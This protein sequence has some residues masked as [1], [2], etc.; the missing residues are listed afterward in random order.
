[1]TVTVNPTPVLTSTLT[2]TPVCDNGSVSYTPTTL[3]SG[4]SFAWSRAAVSGIA[5]SA[6][7]GTNGFAESLDN[8]GTATATVSYVYTLTANGCSNVETV[9]V[10]VYPTPVLTSTLTPASICNLTTFSYAPTSATSGTTFSWSRAAVAG[11][12]NSASSGIN[13]PNETLENTTADPIAVDYVYTL[14]ANG[15]TNVETVTVTVNPG[16][17]MSS[18]LTPAAICDSTLFSYVPTSATSGTVFNWSRASVSGIS[19]TAA[20]GTGNPSEYLNNTSTAPVTVTYVYTL[21][22]SGCSGIQ[23]VSVVVNP[24]PELTSTLTPAAQCNSTLFTYVP[25]SATTG[26]AFE[27][28]RASVSGISNSAATGTDGISE[29]LVNTSTDPVTV[30]YVYTLTANN[31]TNIQNV[32]VVINPTPVLTSTLTANPICDNTTFN[33]IPTS[34]TLGSAF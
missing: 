8:N 2:L 34:A 27:W 30:T 24:T 23:N 33:Y 17:L 3:T 25:T 12:T 21:T 11:I 14:T 16:P 22:A 7:T 32:S 10:D 31:C 26:T 19:N 28:S 18:T 29:V 6:A 15:C 5:N 9:S 1:Y 20:T 13:N 4:T